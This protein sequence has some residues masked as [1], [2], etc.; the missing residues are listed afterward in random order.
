VKNGDRM[1]DL[2]TRALEKHLLDNQEDEYCLVQLLPNGGEFLLPD[3][4][5]PYYAMAPDPSS[6][7]LNLL[8]R[9]MSCILY[10]DASPVNISKSM[11]KYQIGKLTD[12]QEPATSYHSMIATPTPSSA[13]V[14]KFR[15]VRKSNIYSCVVCGD[16]PTGYHYDVLSCNGCKTFF[17][18]T[19]INNRKFICSKGGTCQFNKDTY[20]IAPSA[21]NLNT[22]SRLDIL[23]GTSDF[24]VVN[25]IGSL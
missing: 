24:E 11:E 2:I 8:L 7:M 4:C 21:T 15:N 19:I 25:T 17:R 9:R 6:P 13:V 12:S 22:I 10:V 1:N 3:K 16:K 18:R 5:N 14:K 20:S 23:R